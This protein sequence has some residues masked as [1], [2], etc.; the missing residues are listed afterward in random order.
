LPPYSPELNPQEQ[1][2]KELRTC[3]S[4]RHFD[5]IEDVMEQVTVKCKKMQREKVLLEA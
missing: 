4:N 3:L 2:W 5:S 1:V